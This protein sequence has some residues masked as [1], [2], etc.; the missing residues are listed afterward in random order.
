MSSY[1][2]PGSV[3]SN[4]SIG[5]NGSA[6]PTQ[7]TQ[8]AGQDPSGN[9]TP[10]SVDADG[11]VKTKVVNDPATEPIG[12]DIRDIAGVV[13][14]ASN[15]LPS[16]LT[17]GANFYDAREIRPLTSSDV[18]TA[19]QGGAPWE[20]DVT[21]SALPTGAATEATLSDLNSKVIECDTSS[22]TVSSSALPTGA[23]T[24]AT[25]GNLDGKVAACDTG[26]ISG[27]VTANQGGSWDI[28]N[29]NSIIYPLPVGTN[30]IGSVNSLQTTPVAKTI[31]QAAVSVGTS[32][33]RCTVSGSAPSSDRVLLMVQPDP[34]SSAS[35]FVGSSSVDTIGSDRGVPLVPGAT[36]IANNDAGD[37]YIISSV[38]SQTVYIVEQA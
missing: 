6:A 34:S 27:T 26:N 23:A 29:L 14:S 38:A 21:S 25:L 9:L 13:P 28:N 10:V 15:A 19:E 35:F 1:S 16:Q 22:V 4:P 30:N 2:W 36:F 20:V 8:I 31:T 24:E 18:V 37:Y 3:S 33:V 7:S 5:T 12:V 32:A 17:D 11:N